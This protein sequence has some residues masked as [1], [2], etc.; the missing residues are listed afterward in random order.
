[1]HL[2]SKSPPNTYVAI[3]PNIINENVK[4][5][6]TSNITGIESRI[7]LISFGMLGIW[8]IVFKGLNILMTL[9]VATYLFCTMLLSHPH[10]MTMKSSFYFKIISKKRIV[11]Y[12]I[13]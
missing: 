6:I 3:V 5:S 9:I 7:V 4:R 12:N 10:P 2:F 8:F 11:T 13:P 1:M